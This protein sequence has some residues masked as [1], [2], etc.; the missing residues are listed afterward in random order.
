MTTPKTIPL[1][2]LAKTIRSKNAGVDKITFD[3][4][5]KDR[6]GY[7]LVR[8]S[9]VLSRAAI[10]RLYGIPAER[11]SE[12]VEF[13]PAPAI[14]F[15]FYRKVPSGSVEDTDIFGSQQYGPLLGIQVP[16]S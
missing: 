15:S 13:D 14:K 4:V 11:I 8:R 6:E 12:H 5:F 7:E 9:G 16:G 10:Q 2:T 3:V 1:T